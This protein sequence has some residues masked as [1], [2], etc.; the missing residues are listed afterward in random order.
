VYTTV[1][2]A[3]SLVRWA[4]VALALVNALKF[5]IGW[6]SDSPFKS[7]DRV[8]SLALA[9]LLD[10]Q[11]T[12]GLILLIGLGL[13]GEGFPTIRFAHAGTV[14][15]ALVL[16]HL[17]VRWKSAPDPIRFRNTLFCTLGVLLAIYFGVRLL[18][19]G[20]TF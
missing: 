13:S 4:I 2:P 5:A 3:H 7:I 17:P 16:A 1:L 6:L 14:F 15:I 18:P 10:L 8:L 11:A 12:F 20:W 9:G 19:I